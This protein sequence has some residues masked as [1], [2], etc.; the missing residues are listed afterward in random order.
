MKATTKIVIIALGLLSFSLLSRG[1]SKRQSAESLFQEA[2]VSPIPTSVQIGEA[3]RKS[4]VGS[5]EVWIRFKISPKDFELLLKSEP[6]EN[7]GPSK[8]N[9]SAYGPP[10][11]WTPEDLGSGRRCFECETAPHFGQDRSV[12]DIV[13][14][15]ESNEVLFLLRS[16]SND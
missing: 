13:V 5:I 7:L 1:C 9:Y 6:Y 8:L 4:R 14:N 3:T 2:V 12:K 15:Q 16:W 10:D 11:W